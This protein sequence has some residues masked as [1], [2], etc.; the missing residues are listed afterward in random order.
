MSVSP[1]LTRTDGTILQVQ[2]ALLA[3][4]VQGG[5]QPRHWHR[6][7]PPQG[8]ATAGQTPRPGQRRRRVGGPASGPGAALPQSCANLSRCKVGRASLNESVPARQSVTSNAGPR[9]MRHGPP[10]TRTR[11]RRQSAWPDRAAIKDQSYQYS[12]S[13]A[14]PPGDNRP[15]TAVGR[16]RGRTAKSGGLD[17]T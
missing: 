1:R 7:S 2:V 6:D 11:T 10:A 14:H 12:N 8:Q 15:Q 9:P 3:C 13:S 16:R 4:R 17:D 5:Q